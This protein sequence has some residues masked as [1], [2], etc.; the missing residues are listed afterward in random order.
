M[1]G[2]YAL[3]VHGVRLLNKLSAFQC[4]G[5]SHL[6]RIFKLA[7]YRNTV[8]QSCHLDLHRTKQS[9]NTNSTTST[10]YELPTIRMMKDGTTSAMNTVS[11]CWTKP[12]SNRTPILP[13]SAV[14]RAGKMLL[15]PAWKGWCCAT[16]HTFRSL[17]GHREM[18]RATAKIIPPHWT[19]FTSWTTAG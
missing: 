2:G 18:N 17:R 11:M 4:P 16:V 8:G 9:G 14:S 6:V 7:A 13:I 1:S 19:E 5:Q 3:P 15:F 10:Q 12:I